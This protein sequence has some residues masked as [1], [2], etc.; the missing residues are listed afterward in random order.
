M[1]HNKPYQFR[2]NDT[3]TSQSLT[4][5]AKGYGSIIISVDYGTV[6]VEFSSSHAGNSRRIPVV[7]FQ[8]SI[9]YAPDENVSLT[10]S[11]ETSSFSVIAI[12]P[13]E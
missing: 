9:Q 10:V 7:D 6:V 8:T 4:Y 2:F 11:G 13:L 12:S 5:S 1:L 3:H